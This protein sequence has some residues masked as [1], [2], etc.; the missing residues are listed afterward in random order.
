M[1][2]R[3]ARD[4]KT[5]RRRGPPATLKTPSGV[6]SRRSCDHSESLP[7][8]RLPRLRGPDSERSHHLVVFVLDDVAMPDELSR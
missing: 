3:R 4:A 8:A 5:A 2:D 1:E 6:F 7:S